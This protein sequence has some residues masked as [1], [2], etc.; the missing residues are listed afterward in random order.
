MT[1]TMTIPA[2]PERASFMALLSEHEDI[3]SQLA[4]AA[5]Q[6]STS[7]AELLE[8]FRMSRRAVVAAYDRATLL[9][10]SA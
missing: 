1:L 2:N 4:A 8:R 6:P 10:K 7:R 5:M 3:T 9:A